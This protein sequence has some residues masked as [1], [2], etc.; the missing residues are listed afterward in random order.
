MR[1]PLG[2][3]IGLAVLLVLC[4]HPL[5]G[6]ATDVW[7]NVGPGAQLGGQGMAGRYPLSHYMLDQHFDAVSASLTGGIDA[8]GVPPMIAYFLASVIWALTSFLAGLLISLFGFAF[9]LDLVGG[10]AG[11]GGAGALAPVSRA[12]HSIYADV[13]GG[14]WLALAV[15]VMGIW[16]MWKALVQRR[17]TETAGAFGLSL[18]YVVIGLFFVLQPAATIGAASQWTNKMSV[19]FLAVANHGSPGGGAAAR[20]G[21]T[22]QLFDLLVVKPWVVLNFGGTAHCVLA[23]TG[24]EDSDPESAPVRPLASDPGRDAALARRLAAGGEVSA[25]GKVCID[26][27][28]KYA[29]RF[30]RFAPGSG[31]RDSEYEALD[32]GDTSKLPGADPDRAG[33]RLGVADRPATDAMEEGGQYQR[34]LV[35]IVVFA[36][37][38]GAFCL[39]GSLSVGIVLAQ[40]LLLLLLAFAPVALVA[41]A[42]P[43]R[44]HAFFRGWLEKLAGLLL[45][46]AAYSLVLA[47]LLAVNGALADATSALGW[48]MS[49]GLQAMFFWAVFLQRKALTASLVGIATGPSAP[50]RDASLR[51]LSLYAGGRLA[52]RFARPALRG[53]RGAVGSSGRLADRVSDRGPGRAP[54]FGTSH[55]AT[56]G[57]GELGP[58]A[59]RMTERARLAD[60]A[61]EGE[62][63]IPAPTSRKPGSPNRTSAKAPAEGNERPSEEG[64]RVGTQPGERRPDPASRAKP[65]RPEMSRGAVEPRAVCEAASAGESSAKKDADPRLPGDRKPGVP[66]AAAQRPELPERSPEPASRRKRKRRKG[67][68]R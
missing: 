68:A 15:A 40:V 23:G 12:I 14:P 35:A 16:A 7:G 57:A 8:S 63:E 51:L 52:G 34:L 24:S 45:R 32:S 48:L 38:L 36:G 31:E 4:A 17:Y 6:A 49:F 10:S 54:L 30:L 47:V 33:Y 22:Q 3:A 27:A 50:G 61:G 20:D 9:D 39:L 56:A 46:K 65:S 42:I 1:R 26:N 62:A 60:R 44:G 13:F 21:A 25:E 28:G 55:R 5:A 29:S 41:A 66:G 53:A 11:T 58:E 43:G 64:A 37:E 2:A 19:A 59:P 67:G 18:A